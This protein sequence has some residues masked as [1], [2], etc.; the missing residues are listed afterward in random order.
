MIS[1]KRLSVQHML[2]L[3]VPSE[4]NS[5]SFVRRC[6]EIR[7]VKV[8]LS[9]LSLHSAMQDVSAHRKAVQWGVDFK[10][11]SFSELARIMI[12][13]TRSN[14]E[15]RKKRK[16]L[17]KRRCGPAGSRSASGLS[18]ESWPAGNGSVGAPRAI[19]LVITRFFR[20]CLYVVKPTYFSKFNQLKSKNCSNT[21]K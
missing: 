19:Q 13:K 17:E 20:I 18:S 21:Q 7:L 11:W 16:T 14:V 15:L 8:R 6:C 1:G 3:G 9:S 5:R 12:Q 2:P 4:Y 10:L